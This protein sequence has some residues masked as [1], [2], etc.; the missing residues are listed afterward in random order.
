VVVEGVPPL[1]QPDERLL[2]DVLRV[3]GAEQVGQPGQLCEVVVEQGVERRHAES[4]RHARVHPRSH[5]T[6]TPA[7]PHRFSSPS[8]PIYVKASLPAVRAGKEAFT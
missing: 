5:T 4:V 3:V 8:K 6:T 2:H 1:V 7:P